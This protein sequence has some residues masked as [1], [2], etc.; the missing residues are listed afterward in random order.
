[1]S[2]FRLGFFQ[3]AIVEKN[4]GAIDSLKY[5]WELTKGNAMPL[6][7][8]Y[9]LGILITIAGAPRSI[10]WSRLGNSYRLALLDHRLPLPARRP[11]NH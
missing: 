10:S 1:M 11:T 4:L 2:V 9:L 6:L 7:G 5:S 8:L 3:Q